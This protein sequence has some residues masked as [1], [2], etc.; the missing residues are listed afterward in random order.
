MVLVCNMS[1]VRRDQDLIND[2]KQGVYPGVLDLEDGRTVCLP[3]YFANKNNDNLALLVEE[4]LEEQLLEVQVFSSDWS[5]V[6]KCDC[7]DER[8]EGS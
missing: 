1:L 2:L 8:T 3:Q 4:P 7:A 5:I 6:S